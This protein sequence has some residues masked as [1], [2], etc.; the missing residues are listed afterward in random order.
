MLKDSVW[1]RLL[2]EVIYRRNV[3]SLLQEEGPRIKYYKEKQ[4]EKF[5]PTEYIKKGF[6]AWFITLEK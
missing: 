5:Y 6:R 1:T 2:V 3:Y 4:A